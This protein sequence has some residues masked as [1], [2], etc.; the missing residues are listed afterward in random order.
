MWLHRPPPAAR[1]PRPS[2][3][4]RPRWATHSARAC[5]AR[6]A[7]RS[8]DSGFKALGL[9]Q[10]G[11][12]P[13]PAA[14][15]LH[16]VVFE[17]VDADGKPDPTRSPA[18]RAVF[19]DAE[20]DVPVEKGERSVVFGFTSN[21]P[22]SMEDGRLRGSEPVKLMGREDGMLRRSDLLSVA[23]RPGRR[24]LAI[25]RVAAEGAANLVTDADE[26]PTPV[27]SEGPPPGLGAAR[28]I[29]RR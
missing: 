4:S 16:P 15:L 2:Q 28:R 20:G 17:Y 29:G 11:Q 25:E 9:A 5:G 12:T 18:I 8:V 27:A 21:F 6:A 23:Y 10:G 7:R 1:S 19:Y 22:P 13:G 14:S 26:V 24:R 3:S